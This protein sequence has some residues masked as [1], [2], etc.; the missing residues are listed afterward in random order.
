MESDIFFEDD[1]DKL[2]Y[3]NIDMS[4]C[5]RK[6]NVTK[7]DFSIYEL[8]RRYK[9]GK[10]D[11]A[12]TFQRREVWK[13]IQQSELIESIFMGLPLP[14]FYFKQQEGATFI[15]V[16]GRQRLTALFRYMENQFP[17]NGL[18]VLQ[19]LNGKY[20]RDLKDSFGI[21]QS[22]LEDYQIYSHLILPPT[23]DSIL[24]DIF[25]R[26][27]RGGT[28]LNKQEI[29]NAL[30]HGSMLDMIHL[31]TESESF[32]TATSIR[33]ENDH[34]MKGAYLLTRFFSFLFLQ[35]KQLKDSSGEVYEYRGDI[36]DLLACMLRQM[37]TESKDSLYQEFYVKTEKTLQ[38]I[39]TSIGKG[40]FRKHHYP[41]HPIN[42]N[43]FETTM[44]FFWNINRKCGIGNKSNKFLKNSLEKV[45]SSMDYLAAIDRGGDNV[46][47][48]KQRF[49]MMDSLV[50]RL[51]SL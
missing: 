31:I 49:A 25:D 9:K 45:F 6:I 26:V 38:D 7:R 8:W 1:V 11:L 46:K 35:K 33:L 42:M 43:I 29:R 30:Y 22:Q 39:I 12:P 3:S 34:R 28:I 2:N 24:F 41:S 47:Q 5:I 40:A 15:V 14:I 48:V 36:D 21:Y 17:L 27:N 44:Y 4:S 50:E 16:D 13:P 32:Q 18:R 19:E 23:P 10:L 20:F 37:N 51:D